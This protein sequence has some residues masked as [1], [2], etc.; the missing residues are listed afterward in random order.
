MEYTKTM[1]VWRIEDGAT[2]YVAARGPGEALR[3]MM[4]VDADDGWCDADG[5]SWEKCAPGKV[6]RV[7]NEA[8]QSDV[9]I[10]EHEAH[11][12]TYEPGR[13]SGCDYYVGTARAWLKSCEGK[14]AI[15]ACS[16]W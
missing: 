6:I 13:P 9:E 10:V 11:G 14:P 16:E 5:V 3:L 8:R 1:S 15:L 7:H 4:D 2:Y 12:L